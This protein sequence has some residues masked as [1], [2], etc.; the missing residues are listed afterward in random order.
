L[1]P[2]EERLPGFDDEKAAI[3]IEHVPQITLIPQI[4]KL[5]ADERG[6]KGRWQVA[7]GRRQAAGGR[8]TT[9]HER[10][11]LARN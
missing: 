7:G 3:D 4:E 11:E 9:I 5:A 8:S 1:H 10:H 2:V 6:L